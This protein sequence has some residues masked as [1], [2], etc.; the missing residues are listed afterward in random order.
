MKTTKAQF[1]TFKR[2]FLKWQKKLN[3]MDYKTYFVHVKLTRRYYAQ[4]Q[5]S[6]SNHVVTV[7]MNAELLP[8]ELKGFRPAPCGKHEAFELLLAPLNDLAGERY[9]SRDQI[10]EAVHRII[11]T[12]ETVL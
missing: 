6:V 7:S 1:A 8:H 3:L 10:Q 5:T 2:E 4:V 9:A 12:L 11:R